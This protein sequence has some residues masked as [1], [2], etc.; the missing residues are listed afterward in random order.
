MMRNPGQRINQHPGIEDRLDGH[1]RVRQQVGRHDPAAL[2]ESM[3]SI[4]DRH[5]RGADDRGLQSRKQQ[6]HAETKVDNSIASQPG[7][8]VQRQSTR[9]KPTLL[10]EHVASSQCGIPLV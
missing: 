7:T 9:S 2:I 1:T 6:A 10:L 4:D 8:G 5:E 3:E